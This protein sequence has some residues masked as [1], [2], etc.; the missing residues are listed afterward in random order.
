MSLIMKDTSIKGFPKVVLY[1]EDQIKG[2]VNTLIQSIGIGSL[3]PNTLLLSWPIND[4]GKD[5]TGS[6]EYNTFIGLFTLYIV[7]I[8]NITNV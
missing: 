6:T 8:K 1:N 7:N 5:G 2:C 3:K 4:S